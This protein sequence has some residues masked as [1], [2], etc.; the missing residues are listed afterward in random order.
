MF[1]KNIA[2][3]TFNIKHILLYER[4]TL[5]DFTDLQIKFGLLRR[6]ESSQ[7]EKKSNGNFEIELENNFFNFFVKANLELAFYVSLK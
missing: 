2:R 4:H 5:H 6:N 1:K 7:L 3:P